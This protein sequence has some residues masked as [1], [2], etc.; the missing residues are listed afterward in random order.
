M[1][2]G[3]TGGIGSGKS[4]VARVLQILGCAVFHSDQAAKDAYFEAGVKDKVIALLGKEA[5]T[6]EGGIDRKFI[7]SRIFTDTRLLQELNAIIH[8]AV[9]EMFARFETDNKGR[10]IIKESALLFEADLT[11]DLDVIIVTVADEASRI[12][13]VMRRDNLT[14]EEVKNKMK[15]QLPQDHKAAKADY[16]IDNSGDK[17]V[18][19]QVISIFDK[20]RTDQKLNNA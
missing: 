11:R 10:I 8:P 16:V 14:Y 9:K 5:Y 4:V 7:S 19:P 12:E 2:V 1:R 17:L 13:R 3:L 6:P 15:S 18:I 20:L